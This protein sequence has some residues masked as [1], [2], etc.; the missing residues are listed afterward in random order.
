MTTSSA[1]THEFLRS[2]IQIGN[3]KGPVSYNL[4]Q[5][6]FHHD[7]IPETKR[8]RRNEVKAWMKSKTLSVEEP[9]WNI[10]S[11]PLQPVIVRRQA[12][13]FAR[14]RT[15][16]YQYNY[17]AE[18]LDSLKMVE[19][20]D[21]P[22]KFHVS[23]QLE[24][25]ALELKEIKSTNRIQNGYFTRTGEMPVHPNLIDAEPWKVSTEISLKEKD[26]KLDRMT[27]KAKEWTSK[28]NTK[29]GTFT[30]KPYLGP[31]K[32]AAELQNTI[33]K[34]KAE[35]TFSL[36]K[37]VN[38]P[39]SAPVDRTKLVNR[40][41]NETKNV[42]STHTHSGVYETNKVDGRYAYYCTMTLYC[43]LPSVCC[44]S[45]VRLMYKRIHAGIHFAVTPHHALFCACR[46][47]WSDTGN[48]R[49]ESR[50]DIERRTN[51]DSFNLQG[52][53]MS[54]SR[55]IGKKGNNNKPK[56]ASLAASTV[57]SSIQ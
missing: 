11:K 6:V 10:S 8:L 54:M 48:E 13:N 49:Y 43:P 50:G 27:A 56:E 23:T 1:S 55:L 41:P 16:A 45:A 24:S 7:D 26:Q 18:T 25:R 57:S 30:V 34:Q 17:R 29:P 14:D 52:P 4:N 20:I 9:A 31:L 51:L 44:I 3:V 38:R 12:E 15:G 35:G 2:K 53:N 42:Y 21:R 5:T 28:V 22:T 19:P 32:A 46:S 47:M 40:I 33:R 39:G 37:Q 36:K